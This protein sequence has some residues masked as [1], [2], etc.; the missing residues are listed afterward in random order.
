MAESKFLTYAEVARRLQ[1]PVG[2]L[3]GKVRRGEIPHLRFGP[4]TIRFDAD[5][6]ERWVKARQVEAHAC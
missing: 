4:R 3:Y 1:L 6:I 2:S 5:E